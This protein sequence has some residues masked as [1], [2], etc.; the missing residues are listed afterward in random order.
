MI[1]DSSKFSCLK[2]ANKLVNFY[3]VSCSP[4][5]NFCVT[6]MLTDW[7]AKGQ[8]L[9]TIKRGC[10]T[11]PAPIACKSGATNNIK[12]IE[13]NKSTVNFFLKLFLVRNSIDLK[14]R[15]IILECLY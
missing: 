10:S 15:S 7:L 9:T 14:S 13:N 1:I 6:E 8:Q 5:Q 4:D 12:V 11:T 3:L 2:I